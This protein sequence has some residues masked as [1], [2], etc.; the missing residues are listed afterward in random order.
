MKGIIIPLLSVFLGCFFCNLC[1]QDEYLYTVKRATGEI[2][3][4]GLIDEDEWTSAPATQ[5]FV[6]LGNNDTTPAVV[7]WSK[8]VWNDSYLFVAFYCEDKKLWATYTGRDDQ[9]YLEDVVE[10]F[11]D[12]DRDGLNYMQIDVNPLNTI[13]DLWLNK[14]WDEGGSGHSEWDMADILSAVQVEG[15][16]EN[17]S[18]EDGHWTCEIAFPFSEMA[19][20]AE[21]MNYPP[22]VWDEWR[23][24]V[25]RY[26]RESTDDP[27]GVTTGWSQTSGGQHEPENFGT[28]MFAPLPELTEKKGLGQN[29]PNPA[30][31]QTVINYFIPGPDVAGFSISDL[32]GRVITAK[33][34]ES[35]ADEWQH[36]VLDVSS[37][38][39]G[40]YFYYLK[41]GQQLSDIWKMHVVR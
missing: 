38:A 40:T 9:L 17:N 34:L 4:D 13:F 15:T 39:P 16:I 29:F 28:I 21:S 26:D 12:A 5:N 7:T 25:Y 1:A 22:E 3:I 6:I 11:I 23:F 32:S 10:V 18:D 30:N 33:Q 19:F 41:S 14:P 31:Q 2:V 36:L 35:T 24:N 20:A 27:L 8:M 37:F